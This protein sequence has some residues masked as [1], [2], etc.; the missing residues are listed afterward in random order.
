MTP[1]NLQYTTIKTPL[2][3]FIYQGLAEYSK[4]ANLYHPQPQELITKLADKHHLPREMIYLTAG[5]DEALMMFAAT[6]G[7]NSF[8]F[9]PTFTVYQDV[10]EFGGH[11]NQIF[12]VTGIDYRISTDKI[13][14]ASLI[15][16]ANPNNP[17]GYTPKE[18]VLKLIE[19]NPHAIIVIDEAY[20]QF[21]N[22]TI[23]DHVKKYP[24]A[25]VLR[26]FSKDYAMAGNRLGFIVASPKIISQ[27]QPK[28]QWSN[29]SWLSVGAAITALNHEDYFKNIRTD[30]NTRRDSFIHFLKAQGFQVFPSRI[31]AVLLKFKNS[32]P[33][34]QFVRYLKHHRIIVSQG[35]GNS[36]I[37][38]NDS[39]IRIAIGTP[40]QMSTVRQV[41]SRYKP[42]PSS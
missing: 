14:R 35:N 41:I 15:F 33:A 31:N 37:G 13:P 1:I 10:K 11:L 34:T 6:F 27:V 30:I 3:D 36:N 26:S 32:K 8:T 28:A 20:S 29:V 19:N 25:V 4:T 7:E 21:A 16:L 39:Y 2:P 40:D 17:S 22:L 23:I 9:T 24:H 12:S 18:K 38:L 5:I 42:T